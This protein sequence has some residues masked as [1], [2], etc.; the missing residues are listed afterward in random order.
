MMARRPRV[1]VHVGLPKSGTTY[2]Q[3]AMAS[4]RPQ[5]ATQGVVYPEIPPGS[6]DHFEACLSLLEWDFGRRR[7]VLS[8]DAW[9]TLVAELRADVTERGAQDLVVSSEV[10]A[11]C[12]DR[13]VER[14]VADLSFADVHCVLTVRDPA[15]QLVS[16]WQESV[17]NRLASTLTQFIENIQADPLWDGPRGAWA[18]QD[19]PALLG[20]WRTHVPAERCHIVTVPG[21]GGD[22]GDLWQRFLSVLAVDP[23]ELV[24]AAAHPNASLDLAEAEVLRE[25]NDRALSRQFS[26]VT[27]DAMVRDRLALLGFVPKDRRVPILLREGEHAWATQLA[28]EWVAAIERSGAQVVG[29]LADLTPTPWRWDPAVDL[30][31]ALP[32]QLQLA[33]AMDALELL[34]GAGVTHHRQRLR[35]VIRHLPTAVV[36]HIRWRVSLNE[37]RWP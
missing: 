36:N 17:K 35:H 31:D 19:V 14:L 13:Q 34:V 24:P 30:R 2:L 28:Q 12:D 37:P 7:R 11:L 23:A 22:R 27:Y 18:Y 26:D 4:L 20:R 6:F 33:A 16:V 9:D 25:L 10:L 29:D 8:R 1:F 15:R 32:P 21:A 3:T 5:L